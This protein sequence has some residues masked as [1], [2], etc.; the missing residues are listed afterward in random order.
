MCV[1]KY[2]QPEIAD[3]PNKNLHITKSNYVQFICVANRP[4]HL[5]LSI[6]QCVMPCL[7]T[8][9]LWIE[10]QGDLTLPTKYGCFHLGEASFQAPP[11]LPPGCSSI[12][13]IIQGRAGGRWLWLW[14]WA[15]GKLQHFCCQLLPEDFLCEG[16]LVPFLTQF[17]VENETVHHSNVNKMVKKSLVPFHCFVVDTVVYI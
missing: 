15:Y 14:W 5:W 11:A 4:C 16:L 12:T 7:I 6:L 3:K 9:P 13:P 17:L 1:L 8:V 10:A 2:E